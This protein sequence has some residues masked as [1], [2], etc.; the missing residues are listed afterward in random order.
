MTSSDCR[1]VS[2]K[3]HLGCLVNSLLRIKGQKPSK[4]HISGPQ[5]RRSIDR[6]FLLQMASYA[7]SVSMMSLFGTHCSDRN[8]IW[9]M[10]ETW[11]LIVAV[12][13]I[14]HLLLPSGVLWERKWNHRHLHSMYHYQYHCVGLMFQLFFAHRNSTVNTYMVNIKYMYIWFI[15]SNFTKKSF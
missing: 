15:K 11:R 2:N 6:W 4:L 5:W 8:Y 7:E 3:R 13:R 9:Y 14:Y 1:G 10:A 12:A